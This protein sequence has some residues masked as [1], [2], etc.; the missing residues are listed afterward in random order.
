MY[1]HR[2][3]YLQRLVSSAR[4]QLYSVTILPFPLLSLNFVP[5]KENEQELLSAASVLEV[6]LPLLFVSDFE[7]PIFHRMEDG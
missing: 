5:L 7:W 6:D 3:S 1:E 4:L 2:W